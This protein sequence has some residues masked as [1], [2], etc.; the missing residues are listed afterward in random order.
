MEGPML[1]NRCPLLVLAI[2]LAAGGAFAQSYPSRAVRVIVPAGAGGPD[3]VGR[4]VAAKLTE[5][6]GQTFF[7][8]NHPGANGIVGADIVAKA[9]P[10]RSE[11]HTSEL[12]SQF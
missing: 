10:D 12:Q 3:V 9:A 11:E 1:K 5:L 8:E 2:L 4:I 6:M 7:V